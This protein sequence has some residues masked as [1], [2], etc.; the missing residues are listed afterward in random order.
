MTTQ[1]LVPLNESNTLH[2]HIHVTVRLKPFSEQES[3]LQKQQR[4][5]W[6]INNDTTIQDRHAK[7]SFT[8]DRVFGP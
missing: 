5:Q 6:F 3:S 1:V 7:E 4:G 2:N 8:F